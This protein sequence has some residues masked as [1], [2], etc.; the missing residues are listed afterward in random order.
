[1]KIQ[2]V[3]L[4]G[5]ALLALAGVALLSGPGAASG[6]QAATLSI[7]PA[8]QNVK[9]GSGAFNIEVRVSNVQNIG[10]YDLTLKFDPTLLEYVGAADQGFLASTGRS[11]TC[12]GFTASPASVNAD[13]A[14]HVGCGTNGLIDGG[15]GKPGPNGSATLAVVAFKPKNQLGEAAL[16][17]EGIGAG[18]AYY[19]PRPDEKKEGWQTSL[20]TVEVCSP[21]V[22]QNI[23]FT[24]GTG[25]VGIIDPQAATPT[26][27]PP[28]P[29][30]K[31]RK[32][33]SQDDFQATVAAAVGT[34]RVLGTPNASGT[35]A[36]GTVA[37]DSGVTGGAG[38]A[39]GTGAAGRGAGLGASGLPEGVTIG[40][41]G[42]P[43]GPDGVPVTGYG[44]QPRERNPW[45]M[46]SGLLLLASGAVLATLGVS[47][48]RGGRR[49]EM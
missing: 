14:V 37:G 7:A 2:G 9:A 3:L 5:G 49:S 34:P 42:I 27:L 24:P 13:A 45:W 25:V 39:G 26:A 43:R 4:G 32:T 18:N 28:T 8:S 11:Q 12:Y 48:R 6:Q 20:S 23:A 40:P 36:T 47:R 29:T 1:M 33:V 19:P 16:T 22:E 10:A 31:P 17:L 35:P 30:P 15:Q 38:A 21:C 41:D 44:P 46:R